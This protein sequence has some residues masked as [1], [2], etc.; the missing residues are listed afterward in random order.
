MH[1][2][3]LDL[4]PGFLLAHEGRMCSVI[5]W[6]ILRNDRRQ[7]VQMRIKDI[8][9]GRMQEMK[10]SGDTK[11]EILDKEERELTYSYRDGID[12]VFFTEA[13]E[14]IRCAAEGIADV[15]AWGVDT[16]TGF[17]VNGKL[18]T[19][20][21][22]KFAVVTVAETAPPMKG[23]GT[24]LKEATLDNGM[25]VRVGNIVNVG[26]RIRVDTETME[27]KDRVS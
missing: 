19:V 14:E 1:V 21:P 25:T 2:A 3:A 26:D 18:V 17:F 27:F 9:S 23:A 5:W 10:L 6:N 22:P 20:F 13:G 16:Y 8:E 4:R 12:E 15:I 24:G 11:F 7:F